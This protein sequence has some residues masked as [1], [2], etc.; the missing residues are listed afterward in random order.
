MRHICAV[1]NCQQ[2][3]D[4]V[5]NVNFS[6]KTQ[7][8]LAQNGCLHPFYCQGKQALAFHLPAAFI[9][10]SRKKTRTETRYISGRLRVYCETLT[11]SFF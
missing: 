1:Y 5:I 9:M 4:G 3:T 2:L 11:T 10:E 6:P 7:T 8:V